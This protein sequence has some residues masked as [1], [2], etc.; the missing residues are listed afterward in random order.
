MF[1]SRNIISACVI[2]ALL[3]SCALTNR[4]INN[5]HISKSTP[6]SQFVNGERIVFIGDSITHGGSYH[7][8]IFLFNATRYP[9]KK[10]RYYNAG[11]SGDTAAGTIKRFDTDVAIHQPTIAT[12]MLGMN[13]SNRSLYVTP[14][15]TEAEKKKFLEQQTKTRQTY[16]KNMD[17]LAQKLMSLGSQIIFIKPSIFDQTVKLDSNPLIGLND[18]LANYGEEVA[19]TLAP[20]YKATVVDFQTPMLAVNRML[21]AKNPEAT[22]VGGDRVHP[23][24]KGHLVMAYGF[25]KDQK[26]SKYVSNF[27]IDAEN[28]RVNKFYQCDLTNKIQITLSSVQFTCQS[29]T[30]PFPIEGAQTEAATWVSFQ[31]ELNKQFYQVTGLTPGNYALNIDGV[32]VGEYSHIDL[33]TGINLAN[34][35]NTPMYRQALKVKALNDKR[36]QESNKIRTVAHVHYSMLADYPN[37]DKSN[38]EE[39]V[40][41]LENHVEKSKGKPWY[42]YLKSRIS[43]Y[44]N[45]IGDIDESRKNVDKLFDEIYLINQPKIHNWQLSLI[46]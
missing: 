43:E 18:E 29:K 8:N 6:A 26:E 42:N 46:K 39:V 40:K 16:L 15:Q 45:V 38:V 19:K 34:N 17:T 27:Q 4:N 11:I 14:T 21:Q 7:K 10:I 32:K 44:Q 3:S 22:V 20:K 23:G 12:I 28:Q 2:S 35:K 25:L 1:K 36:A 9:Y 33:A 24:E 37:V 41:A 30:L 31:E 5:R 13:D